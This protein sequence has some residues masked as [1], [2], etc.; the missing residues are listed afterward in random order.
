LDFIMPGERDKHLREYHLVD[1]C[2]D[3][4]PANGVLSTF[5]SWWMGVPVISQRGTLASGRVGHA[6]ASHLGL[7]DFIANDRAEYI[8]AAVRVANHLDALATLRRTL[9][10][11]ME[12]SALMDGPLFARSVEAAYRA[13]WSEHRERT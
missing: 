8:S 7:R 9:R 2:L 1:C 4:V 3:A 5:D 11:R 13:M 6:V 12:R 10:Q